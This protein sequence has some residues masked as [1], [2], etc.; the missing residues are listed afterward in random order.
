MAAL[1]ACR[2]RSTGHSSWDSTRSRATTRSIRR[3]VLPPTSTGSATMT[4]ASFVRALSERPGRSR[5]REAHASPRRPARSKP[6]GG[7]FVAHRR[8]LR[9]GSRVLARAPG[10]QPGGSAAASLGRCARRCALAHARI[11]SIDRSVS[12]R[13][14]TSAALSAAP[15]LGDDVRRDRPAGTIGDCDAPIGARAVAGRARALA[16]RDAL[17]FLRDR[18]ARPDHAGGQGDR[19]AAR[20]HR[21]QGAVHQGTRAGDA[22]RPRRSRIRSR[23]C[24]WTCRR[25]LPWRRS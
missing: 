14:P 6:A 21:R 24:R 25:A 20:R 10:G 5:R 17:S 22:R 19:S 3:H 7:A 15:C 12:L 2:R 16:P 13:R 4:P 23:M 1:A 18:V 9:H 11:D 8:A